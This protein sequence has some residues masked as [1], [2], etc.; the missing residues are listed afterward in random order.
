MLVLSTRVCGNKIFNFFDYVDFSNNDFDVFSSCNYSSLMDL[1]SS[2]FHFWITFF[3]GS[4]LLIGQA[5]I[6]LVNQKGNIV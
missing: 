1:N 5:S 3:D 2:F 6:S 4:Q